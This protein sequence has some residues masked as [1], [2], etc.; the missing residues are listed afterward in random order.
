MT[1]DQ[2]A[3][4]A[5]R[6]GV[7][8]LPAQ[9]GAGPVSAPFPHDGGQPSGLVEP[10]LLYTITAQAAAD[11]VVAQRLNER[12]RDELHRAIGVASKALEPATLAVLRGVQWYVGRDRTV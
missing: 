4:A 2:A 12:L 10:H 9:D 3:T 5:A 8:P 1:A 7:P 6:S 11:P